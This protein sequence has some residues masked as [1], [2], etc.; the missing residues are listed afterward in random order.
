M[1][2]DKTRQKIHDEMFLDI[3]NEHDKTKGS[4]IYDAT[5]P[6]AIQFEKAYQEL[7]KVVDE[8]NIENLVGDKLEKKVNERTGMTRKKATKAIGV[9]TVTGNGTI[10]IGD[11]F[12]TESGIQFSATETKDIVNSGTVSVVCTQAGSI[13]N[14][15]ANQIKFIPVTIA[16]ISSVNNQEPTS[17]GFEAESDSELLIR[18][19]ERVRTPATSANKH[20]YR[21]WAKEVTGVGNAK[22]FPTFSGNNTVKIVIID[23]NKQPASQLLVDEVQ[24]Y[25]DP[26]GTGLGDGVAPAFGGITSVISALGK[27]IDISFTTVKDPAYTDA[28]RLESVKANITQYLKDIAFV[29]DYV[30]YAIVGSLILQSDGIVDYSDL[31]INAGTSNILIG[32]EEV[33]ILGGVTIV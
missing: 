25:I 29:E 15:P 16:G 2:E 14:V 24:N 1:F 7:G 8:L 32:S 26:G 23:S 11:L 4:F 21:L 28:Q 12:E 19:F 20:Q 9:V 13:G 5:M 31:L 3:S 27:A 22:V 6:A 30:S 18:Y 17:D 10:S 33:A